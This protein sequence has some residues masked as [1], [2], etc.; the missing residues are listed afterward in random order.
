MGADSFIFNAHPA[1]LEN[2]YQ[3]F[4]SNPESVDADMQKFFEGFD[5]AFSYFSENGSA[6]SVSPKELQVYSL[7]QAYRAKGHLLSKTNPIRPR[8]DWKA[9]LGI[10]FFGLTK[11]DLNAKFQAGKEIGL[12][13]GTLQEIV[14][15]LQRIYCRSIGVEY[16]Y[17]TNSEL[18]NFVKEQF[19]KRAYEIDLPLEQKKRVLQKITETVVF[20]NRG[21]GSSVCRKP[22]ESP[23]PE[24]RWR[25]WRGGSGNRHGAPWPFECVGQHN[26]Q[27][28]RANFRRV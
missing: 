2:K 19:E 5:L 15:K 23:F 3:D 8:R 9:N 22:H 20:E 12:D 17:I 28:L 25:P 27:N 26:V 11:E 18:H 4:K 21:C 10:E 7:I 16:A 24:R 6:T 14:D 13:N 1:Y